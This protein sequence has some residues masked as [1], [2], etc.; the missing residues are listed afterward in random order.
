[1]P[2]PR[3]L[4]LR[5]SW[6]PARSSSCQDR[7]QAHQGRP[8]AVRWLAVPEPGQGPR[9]EIGAARGTDGRREGGGCVSCAIA[10]SFLP[11]PLPQGGSATSATRSSCTWCHPT[12]SATRRSG[13]RK[14]PSRRHLGQP[15]TPPASPRAGSSR[16]TALPRPARRGCRRAAELRPG[17]PDRRADQPSDL[18][19]YLGLRRY[20][21]AAQAKAARSRPAAQRMPRKRCPSCGTCSSPVWSFASYGAPAA[22]N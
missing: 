16:D 21:S 22:D 6:Q 13:G 11:R 8:A 10:A 17:R 5:A 1:M 15:R 12:P 19:N 3:S 14:R 18:W 20:P 4:L 2:S 7:R 9:A